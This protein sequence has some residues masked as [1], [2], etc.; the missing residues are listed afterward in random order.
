MQLQ[1]ITFLVLLLVF[2]VLFVQM[3]LKKE[4]H[5]IELTNRDG[6]S[7]FV[8]AEL[9]N[10]MTKRMK[11][12][13]FRDSLGDNEGMLFVFPDEQYRTFWMMNTT[14][15]L[16]AIFFSADGKVVDIIPMDPCSSIL[17]PKYR[18]KEKAKY[19]LEVNQGFAEKNGIEEGSS[20][21]K[22]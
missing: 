10:N 1:Y 15:P 9:A 7:V 18:S 14:I 17:C 11:G 20:K 13:M 8:E 3:Q 21:L 5:R 19:V 22:T 6:K 16:D 12:L 4:T 2:L